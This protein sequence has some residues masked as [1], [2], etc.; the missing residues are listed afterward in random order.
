MPNASGAT[1]ANPFEEPQ[2][3]ISEY[4]AQEIATLQSRLDK[5]LGPEYIS[6]RPG[7][8]GQRV[9]YLSADKCINLANEVFGFNGW[10][11]SIQTIQIDFVEENPQTGKISLGLSVIMRVTLKDGTYHEDIGYG[12]IENCKGKAAAFEK[13]KKEGTTDALKRALR[14][15][16]NVLGNCVYDKD[17]VSKV[18]KVKAMPAKWDVDELH[19]HPDFVPKKEPVPVKPKPSS[20]DDDLPPRPIDLGKSSNLDD[21]MAFDGDGEF[22]SDLFDEAD[23]GVGGA[24]NPDEVVLGPE[25]LRMQQQPPTPLNGPNAQRRPFD[26][27][28]RVPARLNPA[29]VTPSKPERPF[30]P[31]P[32]ARQIPAPQPLN[33]RPNPSAAQGQ[34]AQQRQSVPPQ[35]LQPNLAN[36]RMN[37][38]AQAAAPSATGG[39][40]PVRQD[41][42]APST[43]NDPTNQE[44]LPPGTPSASFFSARAVDL[45]RDNPNAIPSGAPAFDPH[46]E[47]PSIR[48]TAGIDHNKTV[49]IARSMLTGAAASPAANNTRD[50]VNPSQ[51]PNRKIGAPGMN[52][53]MNR[54]PTTSSYRPLTRPNLPSGAAAVNRGATPG[55]APQNMNGKRP[56]L[57]DMTNATNPSGSGPA[58]M[59]G[60]NDPKRPKFNQGPAVPP[61]QHQ[62]QQ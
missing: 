24:G 8:A 16:G 12:H 51:D 21:S 15:F 55:L 49:A 61:Q 38:P 30:N 60:V 20:E 10:S 43:T 54:G 5:K 58:P 4:T 52:S 32:A 35:G 18:T 9:H 11:S 13:A 50:F 34:Y 44:A 1:S 53:P 3:R 45:I 29:M 23:F 47:S 6:S 14:N 33:N 41:A 2:R 22:G 7:A 37:P 17:Y 40:G 48:K 62:Q 56:P 46:A 59:G 42:G 28:A 19:R 27:N 57:S 36:N 31:A 25:T 26:N 39:T